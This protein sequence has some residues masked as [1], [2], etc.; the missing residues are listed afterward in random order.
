[1]R[2]CA[3][4][5]DVEVDLSISENDLNGSLTF[6]IVSCLLELPI[7]CWNRIFFCLFAVNIRRRE[8]KY[9]LSVAFDRIKTEKLGSRTNLFC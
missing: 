4:S 8:R 3:G 1:M 5:L 6:H 7:C 2:H 9:F